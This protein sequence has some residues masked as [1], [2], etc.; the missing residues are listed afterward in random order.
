VLNNS[1]LNDRA[2]AQALTIL[3]V[4]SVTIFGEKMCFQE[5][6]RIVYK[7]YGW[8]QVLKAQ[9]PVDKTLIKV[10]FFQPKTIK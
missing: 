4:T 10:I 6:F 7:S 1:K 2:F 5:V 3:W 9:L 8:T